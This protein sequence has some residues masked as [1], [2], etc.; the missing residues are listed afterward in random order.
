MV[1]DRD[2]G[3]DAARAGGAQAGGAPRPGAPRG[4]ASRSYFFRTHLDESGSLPAIPPDDGAPPPPS[5]ATLEAMTTV[6]PNVT[7][8]HDDRFVVPPESQPL[9]PDDGTFDEELVD[10]LV[11]DPAGYD[12]DRGL[13]P[14][15]LGPDDLP[16]DDVP[17]PGQMPPLRAARPASDEAPLP[18]LEELEE[19]A[20]DPEATSWGDDDDDL[21][22]LDHEERDADDDE[23][24]TELGP[25]AERE[26]APRVLRSSNAPPYAG[27]PEV[28]DLVAPA[29]STPTPA[30]PAAQA[31]T[32]EPAASPMTSTRATSRL[33]PLTLVGGDAEA[34]RLVRDALARAAERVTGPGGAVTWRVPMAALVEALRA[35]LPDPGQAERAR[36]EEALAEAQG[37]LGEARVRASALERE[38]AETRGRTSRLEGGAS[39]LERELADARARVAALEHELGDLRSRAARLDDGLARARERQGELEREAVGLREA[40]SERDR[41]RDRVA[42]LDEEGVLLREELG[43]VEGEARRGREQVSRLEAE[44]TEVHEQHAAAREAG[45]AAAERAR[46]L[47]A[48]LAADQRVTERL[49]DERDEALARE[50]ALGHELAAVRATAAQE[51]AALS[52]E[53]QAARRALE[54]ERDAAWGERLRL[55]ELLVALL[56]ELPDEADGL[57]EAPGRPRELLA[58]LR[59]LMDRLARLEG[60]RRR[61]ALLPVPPYERLLERLGADPRLGRLEA[62]CR[63]G[64]ARYRALRALLQRREAAASDLVE[65]AAVVREALALE[66][67]VEVLTA[68]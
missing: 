15:E 45:A 21:G 50:E 61:A 46:H 63:A 13:E 10:E 2:E 52:R 48:R 1:R 14:G 16:A 27:P 41:L 42:Q 60:D 39:R 54:A 58:A 20:G 56:G 40:R 18:S 6:D 44:L 30:A 22:D 59:A 4:R 57:L 64:Q 32:P 3:D 8:R 12:D 19:L 33:E 51:I 29:S 67:V 66:E 65:L 24:I 7:L 62:R 35:G 31:P 9:P 17:P 37:V 25:A 38:L 23:L 5:P 49:R 26:A 53:H 11:D 68:S 47:E 43:E 36:L 34:Q 28:A 55:E